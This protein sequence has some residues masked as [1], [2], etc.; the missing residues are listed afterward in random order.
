MSL[1]AL[2]PRPVFSEQLEIGGWTLS[3]LSELPL[4]NLSIPLGDEAA[5]VTA[6]DAAGLAWP[7]PGQSVGNAARGLL[8][9][10]GDN[11]LVF[12]MPLEAL[13]DALGDT[14][15]LTDQSD[16]WVGLRLTGGDPRAALAY[17]CALDLADSAF[18]DGA[19]ARTRMAHLSVILL[20]QSAED[21]WFWAPRSS[22]ESFI[23]ALKDAFR[24]AERRKRAT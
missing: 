12:G 1:D 11:A 13:S 7:V 16:T 5:V 8:R 9:M 24:L 20:R 10:G 23:H 4:V 21:W 2:K 22:I 15:W 14:A 18:P 17:L 6:L 3:D 19:G